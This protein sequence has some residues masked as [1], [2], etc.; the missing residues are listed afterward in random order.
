MAVCPTAL[1]SRLL[2][3]FGGLAVNF[4]HVCVCVTGCGW[5][6]ECVVPVLCQHMCQWGIQVNPTKDG[7][8]N[9]QLLCPSLS[10]P[11]GIHLA[12]R[13]SVTPHRKTLM[14]SPSIVPFSSLSLSTSLL[15]ALPPPSV[16]HLLHPSN[17]LAPMLP[18]VQFD[19][20]PLP[21]PLNC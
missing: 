4:K 17:F 12:V 16:C 18:Q 15:S 1:C 6:R 21:L 5:M 14:D 10:T 20:T 13:R 9:S 11:T 7:G 3:L 8:V 2:F 19:F